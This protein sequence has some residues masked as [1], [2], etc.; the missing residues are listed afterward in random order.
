MNKLKWVILT[1][2]LIILTNLLTINYIVKT[3]EIQ[4][5]NTDNHTV[6]LKT[7]NQY[8]VYEYK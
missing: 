2:A 7:L 5:I 8:N 4:E 6:V 1:I 3:T